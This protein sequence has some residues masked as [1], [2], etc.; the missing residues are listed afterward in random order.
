[1]GFIQAGATLL[2]ASV[3]SGSYLLCTA[4]LLESL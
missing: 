1:M 4:G 3:A 2:Q